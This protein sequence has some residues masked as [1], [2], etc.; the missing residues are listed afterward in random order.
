MNNFDFV[1]LDVYQAFIEMLIGQGLGHGLG[2]EN[3]RDD[4]ASSLP[5][6]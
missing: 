2:L 3:Y 6:Y 4:Y 1:K 5:A